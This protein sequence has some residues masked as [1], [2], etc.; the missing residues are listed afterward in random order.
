LRTALFGGTFDPIHCAHLTVARE[1]SGD[2][3]LDRVIF[4]PAANPPH[5]TGAV[6][7]DY[8]HRYTMVK[9]ACEG[10]ALFVPSRLECGSEK[11]YSVN[12]IERFRAAAPADTLLFILG[13]DAFAEIG[14]WH[15]WRDVV[16]AVEFI[17]VTR[18]GHTYSMPDGARVHRLDTLA[19]DVS[20]SAIRQRLAEGVA[21][22]EL[23]EP[24]RRYIG[25]RGLYNVR[26]VRPPS[27]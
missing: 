27:A 22:P 15:R 4:I 16:A 21:T 26:S 23:P 13:A 6:H 11:S 9:L 17:V 18:P 14:A 2:L 25:S 24:V 5:K 3:A 8:E 10:E 7:A 19:L 20:S 1:A 12:T